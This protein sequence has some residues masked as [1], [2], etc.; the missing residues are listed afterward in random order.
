MTVYSCLWLLLVDCSLPLCVPRGN[1]CTLL[2]PNDHSKLWGHL[3]FT[4]N[5]SLV[6]RTECVCMGLH[7]YVCMCIIDTKF[8][9]L[10]HDRSH[11][12]MLLFAY[13]AYPSWFTLWLLS[14]L[15]LV[16]GYISK[17]SL[18]SLLSTPL[19]CWNL[20]ITGYFSS[21][22]FLCFTLHFIFKFICSFIHLFISYVYFYLK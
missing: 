9:W 18:S 13:F 5:E 21:F 1:A 12:H 15:N 16:S 8:S 10:S 2:L 17:C 7:V 3:L 4:A 14:F 6:S 11:R 22:L 19:W 20:K